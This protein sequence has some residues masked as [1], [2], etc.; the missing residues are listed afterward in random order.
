MR[1]QGGA[2]SPRKGSLQVGADGDIILVDP[3]KRWTM[4]SERVHSKAGWTPY[5]GRNVTGQVVRTLLRGATLAKNGVISNLP[6]AGR[7]VGG[8]GLRTK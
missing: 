1:G 7:F 3:S 8:A 2:R 5:E 6:P 4:T